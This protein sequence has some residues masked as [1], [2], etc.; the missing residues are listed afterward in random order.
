MSADYLPSDLLVETI[1][2]E[3]TTVPCSRV[4]DLE[5]PSLRCVWVVTVVGLPS[6]RFVVVVTLVIALLPS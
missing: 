4:T 1:R 5:D 2:P 6:E 3:E